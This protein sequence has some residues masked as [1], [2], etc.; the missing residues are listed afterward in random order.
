MWLSYGE[1]RPLFKHLYGTKELDMMRDTVEGQF[2]IVRGIF[3][4]PN[5]D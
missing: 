4:H 3:G 2:K 5:I 1:D